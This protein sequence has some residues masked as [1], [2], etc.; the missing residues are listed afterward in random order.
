MRLFLF[1]GLAMGAIVLSSCDKKKGGED[2][3]DSGGSGSGRYLYVASGLCQAGTSMTTYTAANASNLVYRID[4]G[5]G[6]RDMILADYWGAGSIPGTDTPTGVTDWDADH[7]GVLIGS[8]NPRVE[9]VAKSPLGTRQIL[10]LLQGN[11]TVVTAT[12]KQIYK[13]SDG[14]FFITR[15]SAI[16]KIGTSLGRATG[17]VYV[18]N[19]GAGT[20]VYSSMALG[21][22]G[23]ILVTGST[24]TMKTFSVPSAGLSTGTCSTVQAAPASTTTTSVV[25]DKASHKALVAYAAS[26]AGDKYNAIAAYDVDDTTGA[27]S[28]EIFIY[29]SFEYPGVFPY[30]L[31]GIS[32]MAYDSATKNLYVA[33]VNTITANAT[34]GGASYVIEKFSFDASQVTALTRAKALTRVSTNGLPFYNY[35]GDTKCISQM[36]VGVY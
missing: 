34:T 26:T 7:V 14:T 20:P 2:G 17:S 8:T 27:F 36:S 12:P 18:G 10:N 31:H 6:Q 28:N 9:I 23:R 21:N 32:A 13:N 29:N 1:L 3:A 33:T 30:I 15:S 11:S 24:S 19:C 22:D 4:M 5:S 16:E 25:Y 35:G